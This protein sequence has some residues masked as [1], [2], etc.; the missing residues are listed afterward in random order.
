MFLVRKWP[1]KGVVNRKGNFQ[2][3]FRTKRLSRTP[4]FAP[5]LYHLPFGVQRCMSE[6]YAPLPIQQKACVKTLFEI[7]NHGSVF[8]LREVLR[9]DLCDVNI[10]NEEQ[11]TPLMV[12]ARNG[13]CEMISA[14]LEYGAKVNLQD[15]LGKLESN[16]VLQFLN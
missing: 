2:T 14:L 12:A 3:W 4:L 5:G 15:S 10:R 9:M 11:Q 6:F 7:I 8:E 1:G 16:I 13:N